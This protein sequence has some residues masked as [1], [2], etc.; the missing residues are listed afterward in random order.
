MN[1][2]N[3]QEEQIIKSFQDIDKLENDKIAFFNY[4][5]DIRDVILSIHNKEKWKKWTSIENE[6]KFF[7]DEL[8]L[9]MEINTLND[10]D[11]ENNKCQV[12]D[13]QIKSLG[14]IF[15]DFDNDLYKNSIG[16]SN[17]YGNYISNLEKIIKNYNQKSDLIKQNNPNKK[18]VFYLYDETSAYVEMF[19]EVNPISLITNDNKIKKIHCHFFDKEIMDIVF[20]CKADYFLWYS[21][22]KNLT[23]NGVTDTPP[24]MYVY[25]ANNKIEKDI[26][27][28]VVQYDKDKMMRKT[29]N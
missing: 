8:S 11:V 1:N 21:P 28:E 24:I 14:K 12:K 6:K 22:N 16:D 27:N 19:Q 9:V 3:E 29:Y 2:L 18:L 13:S 17:S 5:K 26:L 15:K 23:I 25:D 7:N 4:S 20:K 10:N